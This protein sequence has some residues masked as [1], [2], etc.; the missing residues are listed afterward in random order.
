MTGKAQATSNLQLSD[1]QNQMIDALK[2]KNLNQ[3]N[4]LD[5]GGA[6]GSV[7]GTAAGS[8]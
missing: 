8:A 5:L 3:K 7:V 4:M 6:V 2:R 1:Q